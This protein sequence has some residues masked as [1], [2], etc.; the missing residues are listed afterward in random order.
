ML[1]CS[2]YCKHPLIP[3]DLFLLV[4]IWS[5]SFLFYLRWYCSEHLYSCL[6]VWMCSVSLKWLSRFRNVTIRNAHV[7]FD[8]AK[9][10]FKRP[11]QLLL[12]PIVPTASFFSI[13]MNLMSRSKL[14]HCC[15]NLHFLS[16]G[17]G[18]ASFYVCL[19]SGW[20][21]LWM[22]CFHLLPG[23]DYLLSHLL[24]KSTLCVLEIDT[25]T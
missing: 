6:L 15:F 12:L 4:D 16:H 10:L 14:C 13:W 3:C 25:I 5:T 2:V 22:V 20:P 1:H 23:F 24:Q 21:L 7:K 17:G 11:R 8:N 18:C 19:Q 9:L